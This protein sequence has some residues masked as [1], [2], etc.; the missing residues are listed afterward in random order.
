M[1]AAPEVAKPF[2]LTPLGIASIVGGIAVVLIVLRVLS[3]VGLVVPH[4]FPFDPT[5]HA[6]PR[7]PDFTALISIKTASADWPDRMFPRE[8]NRTTPTGTVQA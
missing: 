7:L 6:I 5:L 2:Y 4:E 3:A 1:A 8:A